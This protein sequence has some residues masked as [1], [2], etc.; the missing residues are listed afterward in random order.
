MIERFER[1]SQEQPLDTIQGIGSW[2]E[3]RGE[4]I[5]RSFFLSF[6][7]PHPLLSLS[8]NLYLFVGRSGLLGDFV[9]CG[10]VRPDHQ[11]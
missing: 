4:I 9:L 5:A 10:H 1:S 8:L 11:E 7:L 2:D 6:F 3:A